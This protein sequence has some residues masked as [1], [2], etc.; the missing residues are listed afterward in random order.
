MKLYRINKAF[1]Y[2]SAQK[3]SLFYRFH[4]SGQKIGAKKEKSK[5]IFLLF[6]V[7]CL[8]L[9]TLMP[10]TQS[11]MMPLGTPAPPFSLPDTISGEDIGLPADRRASLIM[12]ICNHCPFVLHI[13]DQLV[14]LARDYQ[15]K[16][17]AFIA[18]SS[19]D[20]TTHPQ[21]GPEK[22]K[23]V[24]LAHQYPFPYLYDESQEVARAYQAACTPDFFLFNKELRCVYR[25][26]LDDSR[27]HNN[28]PVTGKDIRAALDAVLANK[29]VPQLQK[30][31]IGCNIK[32]KAA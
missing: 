15:P 11:I 7:E 19:N 21:D 27:P 17:A 26:Q 6:G 8:F 18:I 16:N 1:F 5:R 32:W 29:E 13:Q 20:V 3:N 30:P 22:M 4:R 12:F 25:G 23:E 28:I 14:A 24:A 10:E 9:T 31:S 2:Y